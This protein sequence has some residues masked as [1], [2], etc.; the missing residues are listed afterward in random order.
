M[1]VALGAV[2]VLDAEAAEVRGEPDAA[3]FEGALLEPR[4]LVRGASGL[5]SP[6]APRGRRSVSPEADL[7]LRLVLGLVF[8]LGGRAVMMSFLVE[9]GR[10]GAYCCGASPCECLRVADDAAKRAAARV[11]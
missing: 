8:E 7:A 1:R 11:R 6:D 4:V 9:G 3:R 5:R 10:C 2:G